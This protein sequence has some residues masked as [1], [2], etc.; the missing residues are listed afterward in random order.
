MYIYIYIYIYILGR[1]IPGPSGTWP[2]PGQ[3]L[4][5]VWQQAFYRQVCLSNLI[6]FV[7]TLFLMCLSLRDPENLIYR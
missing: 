1:G 3:A 2:G 6:D 4:F 5:R 7:K